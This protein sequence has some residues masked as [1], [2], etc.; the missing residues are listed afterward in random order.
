MKYKI[1]NSFN[2]HQ[3]Y[4]MSEFDGGW[5]ID[6]VFYSKNKCEEFIQVESLVESIQIV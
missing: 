6:K 3:W 4:I 5:K 1:V 2:G